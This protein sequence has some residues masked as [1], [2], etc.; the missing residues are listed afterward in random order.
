[1][2]KPIKVFN[3]KAFLLFENMAQHAFYGSNNVEQLV[4]LVKQ[5]YSS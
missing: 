2:F 4:G 3:K 5:K 1:M